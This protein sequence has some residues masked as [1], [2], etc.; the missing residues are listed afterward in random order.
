MK[1]EDGILSAL[2]ASVTLPLVS[3][4]A[5]VRVWSVPVDYRE[6][7]LF[8]AVIL[9]GEPDEVPA[10][11]LGDTVYLGELKYAAADSHKLE[12]AKVAKLVE[13]SAGCELALAALTSTYPPGELQS[14]P[15]QVQE[16]SGLQLDPKAAT[17]LLSAIAEVRG[18]TVEDLAD[19]V[20]SKAVGYAAYSGAIIGKRQAAEDLLDKA[21]SLEE[22]AGIVW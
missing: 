7:G 8:V 15:Q 12:A 1:I 17:P 9:P 13:L 22:V 14:W 3:A 20:Q 2:G 18:L 16:A 6:D 5:L 19:R 4:D 21:E 11:A 10:C